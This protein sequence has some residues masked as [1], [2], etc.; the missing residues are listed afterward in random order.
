MARILVLHRYLSTAALQRYVFSNQLPLLE[1][2]HA[3]IGDCEA[4]ACSM[5]D[6]TVCSS[7]RAVLTELAARQHLFDMAMARRIARPLSPEVA[8][9]EVAYSFFGQGVPPAEWKDMPDVQRLPVRGHA[10]AI[11]G[12]AES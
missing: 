2:L 4:C 7:A 9:S 1:R 8:A 6:E 10:L 5:G 11:A 3:H 12:G